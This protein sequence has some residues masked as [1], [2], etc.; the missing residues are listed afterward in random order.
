MSTS[1]STTSRTQ[2]CWIA[3]LKSLKSS[4]RYNQCS[5]SSLS[6]RLQ[7][8]SHIGPATVRETIEMTR[9]S[10]TTYPRSTALCSFEMKGLRI[11]EKISAVTLSPIA[12]A[13]PNLLRQTITAIYHQRAT[14]CP[15][16]SRWAKYWTSSTTTSKWRNISWILIE[17]TRRLR[18]TSHLRSRCLREDQIKTILFS[19]TTLSSAKF[20]TN[21]STCSMRRHKMRFERAMVGSSPRAT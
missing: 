11:T 1:G 10:T 2:S 8:Q 3:R 19:T 16:P 7:L 6:A 13:C 9:L 4:F 17:T 12:R 21:S 5:A 20:S 15:Q 14:K 18:S